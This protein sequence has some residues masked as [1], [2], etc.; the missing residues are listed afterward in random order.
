MNVHDHG[1]YSLSII[2]IYM[3]VA[4]RC[5]ALNLKFNH[6]L[7]GKQQAIATVQRRRAL[8]VIII[9]IKVCVYFFFSSPLEN[10]LNWLRIDSV[11]VCLTC[12]LI[13]CSVDFMFLCFFCSLDQQ[14]QKSF[15]CFFFIFP[16]LASFSV[17][18]LLCA[19][20]RAHNLI[21]LRLDIFIDSPR[22]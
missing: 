15:V 14:K 5:I 19:F 16:F 7:D 4:F 20:Y 21:T 18:E 22:S 12:F 11:F 17:S 2:I 10:S 13:C 6:P 1:Y 8:I 3:R 9:M